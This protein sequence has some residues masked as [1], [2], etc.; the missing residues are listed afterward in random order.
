MLVNLYFRYTVALLFIAA[1]CYGPAIARSDD[2]QFADSFEGG[3]TVFTCPSRPSTPVTG[4][5]GVESGDDNLLI[6]SHIAI[7][8]II[9]RNAELLIDAA[10]NIQ[11]AA[12]DCS[13]TN[14][15]DSATVLNCPEVL[16]TPGLINSHDHLTFQTGPADTGSER[17]DHRHD[18]RRGIRG[19][20]R[21]SSPSSNSSEA[22]TWGEI[23]QLLG[24][25]T[26]LIGSGSATGLV[27]NLD[28]SADR[29]GLDGPGIDLNTFPLGDAGGQL[30][31]SGCDD[32]PVLPSPDVG[33]IYYAHISVGVDLAA[34]NEWL[35]SSGELDD[36][37]VTLPGPSIVHAIAMTS[38]DM[39][40]LLASRATV[41]WSPRSDIMLYGMTTPA[42]LLA[43]QGVKL[44]L[45]T[46]WVTT[47]SMNML[48]EL[49]CAA[50]HNEVGLNSY[51]TDRDLLKMAT[52]DAAVAAGVGDSVGTLAPG[53]IA[54][55]TLFDA[56]VRENFAAAVEAE[57]EDVVLVLKAGSPLFGD[58]SV[59][60]A[61]SEQAGDCELMGAT[62]PGDCMNDRRLCTAIETGFTY[63]ELKAAAVGLH[64][65]YSCGGPPAGE[66]SCTPAR[67]EG[68]GIVYTGIPTS[69]DFD[70][71]GVANGSDNCPSLFNPARPV[72]GFQ[73]ADDDLDG[74]GDVCDDQ[75]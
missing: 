1:S 39:P 66:P 68:D 3:A 4:R 72:D 60:D 26:S 30:V 33:E 7:P 21:F 41:V 40:S 22:R 20:T 29:D 47:G 38:D 13:N 35:C 49:S 37:D 27:R 69:G 74:I 75:P 2:I 45:G 67:N 19:H 28:R 34:R 50:Q 16:T 46:D 52:S 14:G 44:V 12:C 36:T 71:D 18:W 56:S 31:T 24:G 5:C 48:R 32:Y 11:C 65:I 64:P 43:N 59:V 9:Y 10:G 15:Y 51:F 23:R 63:P 54:D 70:G 6:R 8:D 17:Y 55:L 57:Q 53:Y 25:A 58:G 42:T 62:V 61:L 73:Q